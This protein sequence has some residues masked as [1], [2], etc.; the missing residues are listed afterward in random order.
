L[1]SP[2]TLGAMTMMPNVSAPSITVT[3][4]QGPFSD[5]PHTPT[6][7]LRPVAEAELEGDNVMRPQTRERA[8]SPFGDEHATK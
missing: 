7:S 2:A 1:D 8:T 5:P 6:A 4:D 3:S